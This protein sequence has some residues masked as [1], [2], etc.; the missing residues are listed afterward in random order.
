MCLDV[1]KILTR[2][3]LA[4]TLTSPS[5]RPCARQTPLRLRQLNLKSRSNNKTT[6]EEST[7]ITDG[8]NRQWP[9]STMAINDDRPNQR[10]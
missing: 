2:L 4:D 10:Q 7:T 1:L 6:I 5:V 9:E 3:L 8:L